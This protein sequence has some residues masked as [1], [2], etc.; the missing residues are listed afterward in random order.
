MIV[1]PTRT[2]VILESMDEKKQ[3]LVAG[4]S[5]RVS[6]LS[7]ISIYTNSQEGSVP[8]ED[9]F[10]KIHKEFNDDLG[11]TP[12]SDGD[13]LKAFLKHVLPDYDE[14]RVYT[15]DIKKIISWYN[16]LLTQAPELLKE[17][18]EKPKKPTKAKKEVK[19]ES[20]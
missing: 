14:S 9:V 5:H 15:S 18:E 19:K 17:E 10:K 2:G 4:A 13:E 8:L 16:S 12:T 1:K 6:V 7:D 20:E 3:K 11:V